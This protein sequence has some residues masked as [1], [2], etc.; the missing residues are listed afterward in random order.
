MTSPESTNDAISLAGNKHL[1]RNPQ[2]LTPEAHGDLGFV[3]SERPFDFVR[4]TIAVPLT[5][6]E[7]SEAAKDY[8]I[9]FSDSKDPIA[10]AV[11]GLPDSDNLF[12]SE[13]G[14]WD[15]NAYL[16]GYLRCYPFALVPQG[17]DRLAL[18]VDT[19]AH[20]IGE[21][22]EIPFFIDGQ[23]SPRTTEFLEYCGKFEAARQET[24]EFCSELEKLELLSPQ[25]VKRDQQ[26]GEEV[27]VA[28]FIGIDQR[29]VAAL[30]D[31]EIVRLHHSGALQLIYLQLSSIDNWRRVV[32]RAGR[33][34]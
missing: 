5:K 18:I 11:M 22:P 3:N 8:P 2:P 15:E 6:A 27:P 9:V 21:N 19:E 30:A 26:S 31:E 28:D 29:K 24:R 16:P 10:L 20:S 14:T 32:A 7:F 1:Y 13:S 34:R 12:V 33:K 23:L 4:K 25:R 17:E